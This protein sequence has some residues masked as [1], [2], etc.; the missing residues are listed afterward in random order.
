[1]DELEAVGDPDVRAAFL[2]ARESERPVTADE[3]AASAGIHRNVARAR[4]ERLAAAGLLEVGYERR[5]GRTGPGSGRPAKTYAVVPELNAIQFPERHYEELLGLIID[6]L[7]ARGRSRRLRDTGAAFAEELADEVG[8]E[9]APSLRAGVEAVCAAMRKL[10]YQVS[11]E[12]VGEERAVIATPT[13]PLRPLV[14][15]RP[16]AADVDR[17]MWAGLAA[18][19]TSGIEVQDVQCETHDCLADHASCRVVLQLRSL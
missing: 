11:V 5:T 7:P 1:M 2:F 14:R 18:R 9:A 16:D 19:A 8:L 13:C 15:R 17:G 12:D 10:G 4:L 6:A 3:L